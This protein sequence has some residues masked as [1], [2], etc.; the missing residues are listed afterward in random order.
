MVKYTEI[1]FQKKKKQQMHAY[2]KGFSEEIK[3]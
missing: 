2:S 1:N 3:R